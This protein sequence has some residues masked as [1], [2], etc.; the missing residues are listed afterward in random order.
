MKTQAWGWLAVAVVAAGLNASYH[1]G[2]LAWAHRI[3]GRIGH[4][5]NAVL[6][7][8]TG[9]AQQFLTEARIIA[10][11]RQGTSCPLTAVMAEMRTEMPRDFETERMEAISAREQ[12]QLAR[13]EANR[14]RI[15]A[16]VARIRMPAVEL[17]RIVIANPKISVCSRVRV[18]VPRIPAMRMPVA[19]GVHFETVSFGSL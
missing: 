12:A 7:L 13:L 3:A 15:E 8:A 17:N 10:A 9:N 1:D 14:A 5:T 4:S 11:H 19:P 6:A 18:N 2:G 16:Q